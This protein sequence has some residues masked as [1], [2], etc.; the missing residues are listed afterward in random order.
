MG[1]VVSPLLKFL[2][3]ASVYVL[4]PQNVHVKCERSYL[5]EVT[6]FKYSHHRGP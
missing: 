1:R 6:K 2:Y 3:G 4:V 5:K